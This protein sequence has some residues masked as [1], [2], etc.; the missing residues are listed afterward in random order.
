M[1]VLA[2]LIVTG[3]VGWIG[4]FS[5][6]YFPFYGPYVFTHYILYVT[7]GLFLRSR[8][9]LGSVSQNFI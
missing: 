1:I 7:E 4:Q 8:S 5:V 9:V 3:V 6:S 2:L